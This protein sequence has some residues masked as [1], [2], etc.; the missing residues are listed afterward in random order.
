MEGMHEVSDKMLENKKKIAYTQD[1][2]GVKKYKKALHA[3]MN[4]DWLAMIREELADADK[5]LEC[6]ATRKERVLGMLEYAL[7]TKNWH[8]VEH[9]YNELGKTGTGK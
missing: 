8:T 3:A 2:F 1:E 5:Y 4:Y 7:A 6:E 9:A